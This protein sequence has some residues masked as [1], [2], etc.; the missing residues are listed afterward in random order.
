MTSVNDNPLA[1]PLSCWLT[2][3]CQRL[4]IALAPQ[5][6]LDADQLFGRAEVAMH[7]AKRKTL[8][9]LVY[10][11][12]IDSASAQ[13]LSLL[14]ELRRAL[15]H[16]E[17][18]LFLQPKMALAGGTL[19]GAEA[20]VRWQHPQRGLVPPMQFIPFAE[21]TGFVRNRTTGIWSA[22][23]TVTNIGGSAIAAPLQVVFNGLPAGVTMVNNTGLRNGIPYLTVLPAGSLAPG[24]AVS[25]SIQ[26][27][28]PNA[29]VITFTPETDSGAF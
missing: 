25:V 28:N 13:T 22:T 3:K 11:P 18:R 29:V 15:A 5:H 12:A 21:Q 27:T 26:F 24:S 19:V 6:G 16:D 14:S 23:M 9:C 1:L 17:L 20:L 10:E 8:G 4:S 7:A 2:N